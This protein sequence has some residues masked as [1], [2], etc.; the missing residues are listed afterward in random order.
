[1][2]RPSVPH[3]LLKALHPLQRELNTQRTLST[4]KIGILRHLCDAGRATTGE[5]ADRIQVSPQGVS[6]ATRE[7]E[8][9]GLIGRTQDAA[10]RR[11]VWFELTAAGRERYESELLAG[12]SWLAQAIETR[13]T[14]AEAKAL[15]A[16]V[17]ALAKLTGELHG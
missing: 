5:L 12:E 3:L 17:P 2:T 7:L 13:L 8:Q 15:A 11:K 6:L 10:D 16:A 9:M 1:M 14:S 4:G